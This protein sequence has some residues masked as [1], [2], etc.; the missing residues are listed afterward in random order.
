MSLRRSGY[1]E[2]EVSFKRTFHLFVVM[3]SK[4]PKQTLVT[5]FVMEVVTQR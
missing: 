2:H 1:P 3:S 5:V 4:D